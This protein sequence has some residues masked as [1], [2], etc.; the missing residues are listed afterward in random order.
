[1]GEGKQE[2]VED[3]DIP[4]RVEVFV[5][6]SPPARERRRSSEHH[7]LSRR[8]SLSRS[9][10]RAACAAAVEHSAL[11]RGGSADMLRGESGK[12]WQPPVGGAT[13]RSVYGARGRAKLA[14]EG[15]GMP[16]RE[17]NCIKKT[18]GRN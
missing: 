1:M 18:R 10:Q 17:Y 7:R 5:K 8:S 2:R 4:Q 9:C 6:A 3:V 12:H 11:P 16:R 14:S 13:V 15:R